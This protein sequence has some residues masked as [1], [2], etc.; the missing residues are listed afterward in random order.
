MSGSSPQRILVVEDDAASREL[1]LY[2]LER[3]GY[4][5]QSAAAGVEA[6]ELVRTSPPDL[7]ISDILMSGIDGFEL[8]RRLRADS[9]S[10]RI[11][12][13]LYSGAYHQ[14]EAQQLLS[15]LGQVWGLEKPAEPRALLETIDQ[16]LNQPA[17]MESVDPVAFS[18]QHQRLVSEKLVQKV[19]AL[20][21][22]NLKL[23]EARRQLEAEALV[24]GRLEQELRESESRLRQITACAPVGIF[25]LLPSG[26]CVFA[27]DWWDA[28]AGLRPEECMGW[29]WAQAIHPA[30]REAVVAALQ[31]VLSE[32]DSYQGEFRLLTTRHETRWAIV[33]T[34]PLQGLDGATTGHVG[35][36]LDITKRRHLEE[37][38]R[39][40]Q[41]L[42][43]VGQLVAG[44][45]HDFNNLLALIM[46]NTE[47]ALLRLDA[48]NAITP[49][50]MD[51]K[52][53]TEKAAT[54]IR[55]LLMFSR[56]EINEPRRLD[57]NPA[58]SIASHFLHRLIGENISIQLKL[59]EAPITV[60]IDPSHLEQVLMNLLINARDAMP[61]GG[62]V[63]IETSIVDL[64]SR[65]L[66]PDFSPPPG[67]YAM[68][69]VTDTGHGMDAATRAHIFE[70]F[71]TTKERS[72]GTGL[73]LATVEGIVRQAGGQI[74]VYS[75]VDHGTTFKIFLPL[76]TGAPETSAEE[77]K[78]VA[79]G[80]G[81]TILLVEDEA[82][83]RK[84][85]IQCLE[86]S[87]YRVLKASDGIEAIA[88]GD[89]HDWKI[90]LLLSD[91]VMPRL[92]GVNLLSQ[93]AAR[94]PAIQLML[95]TGYTQDAKLHQ[96]DLRSVRVIQK[97]FTRAALLR[98]IRTALDAGK[99][100]TRRHT[101]LLAEDDPSYRELIQDTL[102][103]AGFEVLS[104]HDGTRALMHGL[105][106]P[107]HLAIL[108]VVMPKSTGFSVC[109]KLRANPATA[110]VPIIVMSGLTTKDDQRRALEAG[111]NLFLRKPFSTDE[112]VS[113]I[114]TLLVSKPNGQERA[115]L[116]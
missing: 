15:T 105:S 74:A 110:S 32:S 21:A 55:Q 95:M 63:T 67:I 36:L 40:A 83:L 35:M 85:V 59:T 84:M 92:G 88:V 50:L 9:A 52:S 87:G 61:E 25:Q 57:L 116:Q 58:I 13:V 111:A 3:S 42:E 100:V 43:A 38:L 56:Q 44:V 91:A 1:L 90:D 37:Q 112:L 2:L 7:I 54:V 80:R 4:H 64:S 89:K 97:P 109:R 81:E 82:P 103:S 34:V 39:Q 107:I 47:L 41:K 98:K 60:F 20:T 115:K 71:F 30:E 29:G 26:E 79:M 12:V 23:E 93:V 8:I 51:V 78:E 65:P 68:V 108:D 6:L 48:D 49:K 27:N 113:T 18:E 86:E 101:I 73:G 99:P 45:A 106:H 5:V 28:T 102:Q 22:A 104:S 76:S 94:Y 70:P 24:R 11:P 69:S 75:E 16:A 96:G 10:A 19:Q 62:T 17:P 114:N 53:A 31:K 46:G 33:R 14:E 77:E 66:A 72:K